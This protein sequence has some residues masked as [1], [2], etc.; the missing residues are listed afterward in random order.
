LVGEGGR[1]EHLEPPSSS[2]H[3]KKIISLFPFPAFE[4]VELMF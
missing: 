2:C 3:Q 4:G 1:V